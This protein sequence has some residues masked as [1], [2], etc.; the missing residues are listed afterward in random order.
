MDNTTT[1]EGT[2]FILGT[3]HGKYVCFAEV[4]ANRVRDAHS[5]RELL[6]CAEVH[7]LATQ[8]G[9]F[10]DP[11]EPTKVT[12]RKDMVITPLDVSSRTAA[13]FDMAGARLTLFEELSEND[14][15]F[16]NT[17]LKRSRELAAAWDKARSPIS[18]P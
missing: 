13:V 11:K 6:K 14:R 1:A 3:A 9:M 17:S 10:T 8:A 2:W 18:L 4:Q 16:Y 12:M 7:E 15:E 5:G